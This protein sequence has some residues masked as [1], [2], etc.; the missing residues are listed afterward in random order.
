[1]DTP[2]F[3]FHPP[4]GGHFPFGAVKYVASVNTLVQPVC[5]LALSFLLGKY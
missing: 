3:V 2:Q 4:V 5:G 1:M